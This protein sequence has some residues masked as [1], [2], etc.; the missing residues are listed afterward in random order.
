MFNSDNKRK[1]ETERQY[2]RKVME[3]VQELGRQGI[4]F[5]GDESNVNFSLIL[6]L[7]GKD[8]PEV[9]KRVLNN[10]ALKLKKYIHDQYQN[11]FI[12]IMA[13]HVLRLKLSGIHQSMLFGLVA[14]EYT[15]VSNKNKCLLVYVGPK[16]KNLKFK[17]ILLISTK[18][19]IYRAP[20]SSRQ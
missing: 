17:E 2:F 9:A 8:D 14:D 19:I 5:Q 16:A 4:Q 18:S 7:W 20:Q 11:E 10:T 13:K 6:L 12:D 15:D 3:T 1:R